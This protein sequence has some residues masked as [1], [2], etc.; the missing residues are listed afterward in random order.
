MW[1]NIK[2]TAAQNPQHPLNGVFH[3]N[4]KL[5]NFETSKLDLENSPLMSYFKLVQDN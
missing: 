2:E 1:R 3:K 4:V 5:I